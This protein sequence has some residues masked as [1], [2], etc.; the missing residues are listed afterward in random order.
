MPVLV[1]RLLISCLKRRGW[2]PAA[3]L[4][5]LALAGWGAQSEIDT[6][7]GADR[8]ALRSAPD[9]TTVMSVTE[10]IEAVRRDSL[11]KS[12]NT[13]TPQSNSLTFLRLLTGVPYLTP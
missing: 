10:M 5:W 7:Q 3:I 4:N 2:E 13:L 6:S 8:T 9:S 11:C 12:S 1:N